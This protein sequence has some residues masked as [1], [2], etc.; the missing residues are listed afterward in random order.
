MKWVVIP[1]VIAALGIGFGAAWVVHPA[2]PSESY[3]AGV[4][5]AVSRE[6]TPDGVSATPAELIELCRVYADAG[7]AG[8]DGVTS[9]ADFMVGCTDEANSLGGSR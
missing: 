3:R 5:H 9:T 4:A 6:T 8:L 1:M 2:A 7:M